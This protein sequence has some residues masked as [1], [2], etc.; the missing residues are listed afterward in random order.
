[1]QLWNLTRGVS[2]DDTTRRSAAAWNDDLVAGLVDSLGRRDFGARAL[3]RINR[4][5]PAASWSVYRLPPAGLPTM[6]AS[7]SYRVAD[8]TRECWSAYRAGLYR[9]DDT[10]ARVREQARPGQLMMTHWHA[11]EI[12]PPHREQIYR[13]HGVRERLSVV[14]I[15]DDRALLAVNCYRHDHQRHFGDREIA[16]LQ[17]LAG[18]LVACVRRHDEIVRETETG[19]AAAGAARLRRL[20]PALTGREHDVCDRLL[21]GWTHE[22]IAADL[23]L[24]VATVV[25]YRNRA[26]VRLGIHFRSELFALAANRGGGT[27]EP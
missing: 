17:D 4:V 18:G 16:R 14:R 19:A 5:V 7:G 6:I 24:S 11:E 2:A 12:R 20:C 23:G 9:Q 15:E 1:M 26:F 8:T 3:A 10:F 13:R 25:T 27:D 21:R 22:G